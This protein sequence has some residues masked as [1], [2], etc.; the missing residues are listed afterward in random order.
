MDSDKLMEKQIKINN[1]IKDKN[2][3]KFS[4]DKCGDIN[5]NITEN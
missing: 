5:N 4:K 1:N 2:K 3:Y